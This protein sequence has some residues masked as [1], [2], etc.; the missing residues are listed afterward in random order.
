MTYVYIIGE[1]LLMETMGKR[2]SWARERA[3][4]GS[5]RQAAGADHDGAWLWRRVGIAGKQPQAVVP[6]KGRIERQVRQ[7]GRR[8]LRPVKMNL[9]HGCRKVMGVTLLFERGAPA[10]GQRKVQH[11]LERNGH[12]L[13]GEWCARAAIDA[14]GRAIEPAGANILA[15]QRRRVAVGLHPGGVGQESLGEFLLE[16]V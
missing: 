6:A 9:A 14:P 11:R 13:P 10:D 1:N 15:A 3:G 7:P 5:A 12:L 2:L 8:T 4:F 16:S